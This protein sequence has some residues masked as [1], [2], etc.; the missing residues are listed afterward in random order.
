[1][2]LFKRKIVKITCVV[3]LSC[4]IVLCIGL[5]TKAALIEDFDPTYPR[6]TL[7]S[8]TIDYDFSYQ[9]GLGFVGQITA[10]SN[11]GGATVQIPGYDYSISDGDYAY[12]LDATL[13]L[14]I[15]NRT[16]TPLDGSVSVVYDPE[17]GIFDQEYEDY[18]DSI[19]PGRT[20]TGTLVE[21]GGLVDFGFG[22]IGHTWHDRGMRLQFLMNNPD[23]GTD[24]AGN[25]FDPYVYTVLDIY[26]FGFLFS[27]RQ[28]F[29]RLLTDWRSL[30]NTATTW[31]PIPGA[32]WL[33]GS[34]LFGL[35]AI[36]RRPSA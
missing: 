13:V 29:T 7:D 26:D 32:V 28:C 15:W 14:N 11:G 2:E 12:S 34:G 33:L 19:V 10:T 22:V 24:W 25:E 5:D 35:I 17:A 20:S 8:A 23:E 21:G 31:V 4:F 9:W 16:V 36:R 27:D 6:I 1:M 18:L 3:M 30:D